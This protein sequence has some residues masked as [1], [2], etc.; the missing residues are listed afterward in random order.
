MAAAGNTADEGLYFPAS[1]PNVLA[2]GALAKT[3]DLACYS[4]RPKSGQKALDLVAPGGNAGTGTANCFSA[5]DYDILGLD[6]RSVP[7]SNRSQNGYGLRAGTSE[8]APQVAGAAS[9]LR[10]FRSDLSAAQI[11]GTLTGSAKTVAGGKLLDMGA[12]VRLAAALPGTSA[13][14]Y[15]LSVQALQNTTV[16]KT[17]SAN[18][19]LAAGSSSAPYNVAGLSAGTYTL[20]ATLKVSGQTYTGSSTVTVS[21]NVTGKTVTAQ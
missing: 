14:A 10:A 7:N 18:G 17:F 4:A 2:V 8:A 16:V 12:A 6:A 3:D 15:S 9:L 11:K 1:D 19:T 20:S 13:R 21:G 5:S